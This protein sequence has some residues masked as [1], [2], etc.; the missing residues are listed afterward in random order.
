MKIGNKKFFYAASFVA[1]VVTSLFFLKKKDKTNTLYETNYLYE[2]KYDPKVS[3]IEFFDKSAL[4]EAYSRYEK[5]ID[6]GLNKSDAF[7]AVVEDERNI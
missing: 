2:K 6:L 4:E 3:F 5:Y 7:K 1:G